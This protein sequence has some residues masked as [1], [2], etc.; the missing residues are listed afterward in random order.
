[1]IVAKKFSFDTNDLLIKT[2][3][4][5]CHCICNLSNFKDECVVYVEE[6]K[7]PQVLCSIAVHFNFPSLFYR[8]LEDDVF[9]R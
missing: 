6:F 9:H 7:S 5:L 2:D 1:L 3:Q 8:F 4:H